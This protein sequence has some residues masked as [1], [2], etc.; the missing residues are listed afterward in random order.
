MHDSILFFTLLY[1]NPAVRMAGW[2]DYT[3][4]IIVEPQII[5]KKRKNKAAKKSSFCLIVWQNRCTYGCL[6]YIKG[7][8]KG[9][10][11]NLINKKIMNDTK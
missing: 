4:V 9:R 3:K 11:L 8:I 6:M 2:L 1:M 7:R 5:E 10:V